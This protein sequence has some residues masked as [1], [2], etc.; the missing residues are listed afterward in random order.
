MK[1]TRQEQEM[2]DGNGGKVARKALF[3]YCIIEFVDL[4]L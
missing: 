2:L 3:N 1:L 4:R